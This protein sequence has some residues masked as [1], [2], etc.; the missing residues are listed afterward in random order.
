MGWAFL[1]SSSSETAAKGTFP[2][3]VHVAERQQI[4]SGQ[5]YKS[6]VA[7]GVRNRYPLTE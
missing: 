2:I 3:G 7:R 6:G 1:C 4:K 5:Q